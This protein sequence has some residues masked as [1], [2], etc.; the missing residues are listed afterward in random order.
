MFYFFKNK[1]KSSNLYINQIR[2][3]KQN[4]QFKNK[5]ELIQ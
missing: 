3:N 2:L 5:N 4:I 1:T